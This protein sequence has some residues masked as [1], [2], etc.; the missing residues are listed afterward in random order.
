M[1]QSL[2]APLAFAAVCVALSASSTTRSETQD[3]PYAFDVL[4]SQIIFFVD[5]LGFS[6]SAGHFR[7]FDGSLY[8]EP[9]QWD[10]ARVEVNIEV[11]SIDMGDATWNE[12]MLADNFFKVSEHPQMQFKS[13]GMQVVDANRATLQGELT[14]LGETRPVSLDVQFNKAGV[15]PFNGKEVVGFSASGS[16]KRSDFGMEAYLPAV[17]DEIELRIEVEATRDPLPVA[18]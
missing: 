10:D 14:L 16:L 1:R 2:F 13:T 11:A 6:K 5:H 12:H 15:H 18:E 4:H 3:R 7:R 17:G 9:G 8:F